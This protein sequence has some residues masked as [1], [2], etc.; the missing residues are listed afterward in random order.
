MAHDEVFVADENGHPLSKCTQARAEALL[1]KGQAVSVSAVPPSI[2]LNRPRGNGAPSSPPSGLS[3]N[4]KKR[5]RKVAK[6][7][8]RDGFACFYCDEIM[9]NAD[10][11]IEHLVAKAD[12][13]TD[14]PSNL[15]LAHADC[16]EMAANMPV[17]GKVL[18]RESLRQKARTRT[19]GEVQISGVCDKQV[20]H[21][22]DHA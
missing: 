17:I 11:T 5:S 12:G 9:K 18:L 4:Q 6:L 3:G 8:A 20:H 7:R 19:P 16:N 22:L 15:V 14:H 13:G 1:K 21:I 10:T 2:R